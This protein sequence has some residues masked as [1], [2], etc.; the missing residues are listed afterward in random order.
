MN[1]RDYTNGTGQPAGRTGAT[2]P[3]SVLVAGPPGRV[4]SLYSTFVSDGRFTVEAQATSPEDLRAK[5]QLEPEAV[6][7]EGTVF[8][9][10]DSFAQMLG[11][12][13]GVCF[14]LFPARIT[15]GQG[16]LDALHAVPCVQQVVHDGEVNFPDLAGRVYE[17]AKARR[18]ASIAQRGG[19]PNYA[20][21]QGPQAAM[22]GWRSIAVWNPQGGVGKSTI[23]Q[24]LAMEAAQRN[25][26]SLL[27]GL[28]APDTNPL[29]MGLRSEP[30]ILNWREE[31]TAEAL[32]AATQNPQYSSVNVLAGFP[33]PLGVTD[34]AGTPLDAPDAL[35]TLAAVAAK[36]GYGVVVFDVSAQQLAAAA[37]SASNTI[38]IPARPTI[39]GMLHTIEAIRLLNNVVGD[40]HA[41]ARESTHLVVNGVRDATWTPKDVVKAGGD[42]RSEHQDFPSLA[43][44]IPDDPTIQ[45]A[46]NNK[47]PAYLRS[48]PLRRAA[49]TLGDMLFARPGGVP[50]SAAQ[51][52]ARVGKEPKQIG[53]GPIR[54]KF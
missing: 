2:R 11:G 27:V 37:L 17:S 6:V 10:P 41:I 36:A 44:A 34:Y 46:A 14:V 16:E 40:R 5:L 53:L 8:E 35:P 12:Y 52:D 50:R 9:G 54:L 25:L 28:G 15:L 39:D 20:M 13:D 42:M 45:E 24:A 47:T 4:Q 51:Q 48:E 49:R 22:A 7:V 31:P 29:V 19:N 18:Q 38:I 43:A 21:F 30:N 26:P 3:V 32:R 1:W 33:D 23:A